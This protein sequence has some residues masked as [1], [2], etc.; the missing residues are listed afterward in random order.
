ML[1][2]EQAYQEYAGMVYRYLLSLS[3]DRE[4]AEELTQETFYQAVKNA[5]RFDNS[6]KL[7][8]WLCAIAKNQLLAYR[9]KH[10]PAASL[11]DMPAGSASSS[12]EKE[13]LTAAGRME[14]LKSLHELGEPAREI[15]YLRLFGDLSFR[16]I[17]DVL[18]K[19]EN[20]ARVNFYRGKERLK[21]EMEAHD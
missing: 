10:P 2:M 9:R 6:C 1:S 17:G 3:N 11:E 8:T 7:S 16:E 4:L 15:M 12:A 14:L 13:A 21:K 5:G 18:G 20:W 19:S